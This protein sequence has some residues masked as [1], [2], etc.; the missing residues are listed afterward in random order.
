MG[1]MD[2]LYLKKQKLVDQLYHGKVV[3]EQ[4]HAEKLRR[5]ANRISSLKPGAKKAIFEGLAMK[6]SPFDV[7]RD[8]YDRRKYERIKK[9]HK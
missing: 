5:Q 2:K 8:E 9:Y 7:M 6:K 4:I 3:S 1:L